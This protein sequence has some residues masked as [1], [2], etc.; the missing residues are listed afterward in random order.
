MVYRGKPS[1]GCESCRARRLKC[2]RARKE[3]SGYQDPNAVRFFDQTKEV[4]S[5]ARSRALARKLDKPPATHHSDSEPGTPPSRVAVSW[6]NSLD[7]NAWS[8]VFTYFVGDDPNQGLLAFL[9]ELLRGSPSDCLRAI[10]KSLGLACVSR[11]HGHQEARRASNEQYSIALRQTNK[12][13]QDP[14]TAK[15]DSTLAAVVLLSLKDF[16]TSPKIAALSKAARAERIKTSQIAVRSGASR[17]TPNKPSQ[18]WDWSK[19]S[20]TGSPEYMPMPA[21][22]N[23]GDAPS[24][25]AAYD[26]T[27]LQ[28]AEN[29][30]YEYQPIEDFYDMLLKFNNLSIEIEA[31]YHRN[32][33]NA[34]IVPLIDEALQLDTDFGAWAMTFQAVCGYRV[35]RASSPI[36]KGGTTFPTHSDE[37]HIYPSMRLA[38]FWNHYRQARISLNEMIETMAFGMSQFMAVP[39]L[40]GVILQAIATNNRLVNDVCASVTY[41]FNSAPGLFGG[42]ARL[43][44]PLFI[45][46]GSIHASPYTQNW[47]ADVLEAIARC[48]GVHQANVMALRIRMGLYS[49]QGGMIPGKK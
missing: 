39:R 12:D 38:T 28:P 48:S 13:L 34:N 15:A 41:F 46:A 14:V 24:T 10:T 26:K 31:T 33:F 42:V 11:I 35:C 32:Q 3:C 21:S 49:I 4:T 6:L 23:D 29:A 30:R 8:H 43:P 25:P 20:N 18:G 37:Y 27:P 16:H 5:K 40:E 19:R 45:A 1:P 22:S 47:I 36:S 7:D 2:I 44:W 9:P 17:P